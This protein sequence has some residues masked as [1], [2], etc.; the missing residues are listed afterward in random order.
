MK[1]QSLFAAILLLLSIQ[2]NAALVSLDGVEAD[3]AEL[4]ILALNNANTDEV[5]DISFNF[6]FEAFDPGW[7]SDLLVEVAHLTSG[8]FFQIGTQAASCTDFGLS[9]EFDLGWSSEPGIFQ[10]AGM[11]SL[12][13]ATILDGSGDWEVVIADSFDDDGVDG[14]FLAGSFIE[15]NQGMR[16]VEASAPSILAL[17]LFAG[18]VCFSRKKSA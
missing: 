5:L 16:A 10:A 17:I 2:A 3:G 1:K 6:V 14:V 18:L 12:P 13:V 15:V 11:I 9:C 4:N 7:G 8:S